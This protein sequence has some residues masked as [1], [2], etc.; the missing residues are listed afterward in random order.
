MNAIV[1]W[2][3]VEGLIEPHYPKVGNGRQ[4]VGLSIMLRVYFI[5][6]WF[7]LAA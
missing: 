2:S 5:Q 1:P 7:G 4:L 6:Q 3:A